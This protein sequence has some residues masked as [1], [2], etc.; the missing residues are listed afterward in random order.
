M[1]TTARQLEE[2]FRQILAAG[3][4]SG[5]SLRLRSE[6]AQR[7][8][9]AVIV[10]GEETG[11]FLGV[12]VSGRVA[13]ECT[14]ALECRVDGTEDSSPGVLEELGGAL[15]GYLANAAPLAAAWKAAVAGGNVGTI[16]AAL[17][18][19]TAAGGVLLSTGWLY[20]RFLDSDSAYAFD[21]PTRV[22]TRTYPLHALTSA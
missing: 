3:L 22:L 12:K 20:L 7:T 6:P 19:L 1:S 4:P 16:A 9:P 21:G 18:A 13:K 11:D 5:Y 10:A 2:T 17:A 15:D 8:L 14:I